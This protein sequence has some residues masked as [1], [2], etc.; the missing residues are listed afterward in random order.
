MGYCQL[1]DP[2]TLF[3]LSYQGRADIDEETAQEI[4]IVQLNYSYSYPSLV[5]YK[6][7]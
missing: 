3:L 7:G 6:L 5:T 2:T 1:V 4:F